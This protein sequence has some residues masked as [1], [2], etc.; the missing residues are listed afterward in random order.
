MRMAANCTL[1]GARL[2]VAGVA[3]PA[4]QGGE[5]SGTTCPRSADGCIPNSQC[6]SCHSSCETGS[7]MSNSSGPVCTDEDCTACPDGHYLLPRVVHSYGGMQEFSEVSAAV[8]VRRS[9]E[10]DDTADLPHMQR[11]YAYQ[12]GLRLP[13]TGM[14][15][16][17]PGANTGCKKCQMTGPGG[18][19]VRSW[20]CAQCGPRP[21]RVRFAL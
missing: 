8:K 21:V 4:D 11:L 13:V 18:A 3:W 10:D 5:E 2:A 14:C 16:V 7:C 17:C 15:K 19:G 9:I 1:A 20:R 6:T 12:T